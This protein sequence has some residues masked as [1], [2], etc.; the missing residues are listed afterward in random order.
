MFL[1]SHLEH[2]A[3][4]ICAH[5]KSSVLLLLLLLLLLSSRAQILDMGVLP[6]RKESFSPSILSLQ[7]WGLSVT[8]STQA[9]HLFII[10]PGLSDRWRSLFLPQGSALNWK[11]TQGIKTAQETM[12]RIQNWWLQT[13]DIPCFRCS[14]WFNEPLAS[15]TQWNTYTVPISLA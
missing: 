9:Y 11:T 8:M 4:W 5:Y 13:T 12:A 14:M 3:G 6:L 7:T 1:D 15:L 2:P 10:Y